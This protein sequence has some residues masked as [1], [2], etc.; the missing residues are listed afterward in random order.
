MKED[1]P[2]NWKSD[3]LTLIK[4]IPGQVVAVIAFI[5]A[6]VG[7]F[8]LLEWDYKT[9]ILTSISILL[10]TISIY[11]YCK[12]SIN[13]QTTFQKG[14]QVLHQPVYP[15]WLRRFALTL[16]I[17]IP[18][19]LGAIGIRWLR[20]KNSPP[21]K[22][23]I[24]IANLEGKDH[25]YGIT[26]IVFENLSEAVSGYSDVEI[27][28]LGKVMHS[29]QEGKTLEES[30][31]AAR[32]EGKK[33]KA[34]IVLWGSYVKTNE[35]VSVTIYLEILR[36][37]LNKILRKDREVLTLPV[38]ALETL[39][40]HAQLT[41]ELKYL[42][43]LII[44]IA[45]YEAGDYDGAIDRLSIAAS[46]QSAVPEQI[47]EPAILYS[48][49]GAAFLFT[50]R[51]SLAVADFTEVI[52]SA[53]KISNS[54]IDLPGLYYTR[55]IAHLVNGDLDLQ[56][57][58]ENDPKYIVAYI[59]SKE[60]GKQSEPSEKIRR[61]YSLAIEDFNK[62]I[63]LNKDNLEVYKTRALAYHL[64]EDYD[65][66][67]ADYT[68]LIESKYRN[69]DAAYYNRGVAYYEKGEPAKAMAD[70][71]QAIQLNPDSKAYNARGT[72]YAEQKQ[73]DLAISEFGKV[74]QL[75]KYSDIGY[76]NRGK[77]YAEKGELDLAI[78]DFNNAIR[79]N[80]NYTDAY[81]E[82]GEVHKAKNNYDLAIMD[83]TKVIETKLSRPEE[84]INFIAALGQRGEIH[85]EK[86]EYDSAIADFNGIIN[87]KPSFDDIVSV[88]PP[89]V[90]FL[91]G[92]AYLERGSYDLAIADFNKII[93]VK[94][95]AANYLNRAI[96]YQKTG[97]SEL[98]LA[99]VN[100][101]I[102]MKNDFA[103]AYLA[104]GNIYTDDGKLDLA[105]SD[106]NEAIRLDR[107]LAEAYVSRANA[108]SQKENE[109]LA[110][111]DCDAA[112]RLNPKLPVAYFNR[113]NSYSK[114]GEFYKA[115]S[116]Y[117]EALKLQPN[118]DKVKSNLAI[119]YYNRGLFHKKEGE[120]DKAAADFRKALELTDDPSLR[121][122]AEKNLQ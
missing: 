67:I 35:K 17:L 97:K 28:S 101:A 69:I 59:G 32:E 119:T 96:A 80:P 58:N 111:S 66:A 24:L 23:I 56:L 98:A 110:I 91:R 94:P 54:N 46:P 21:D 51:G 120:V 49:R 8:R 57:L 45:R 33:Q 74:I 116:D 60:H 55:G 62:A 76:F 79:L 108:Y 106:F 36:N 15:V 75:S 52:N 63:E 41:D 5:T 115:I 77:V 38:A 85:L 89:M 43:F 2:G 84:I 90:Y 61:E 83:F 25:D 68:K 11:I 112:I 12:R 104:R 47:V 16:V 10:W 3:L 48:Y 18:I 102:K 53:Q 92:T 107:N 27:R 64:N 42:T 44:G 114:K 40:I 7:V 95:D 82:R 78:S 121:R 103:G 87:F 118:Y 30:R 31:Q 29:I 6:V 109:E 26:R 70:F 1:S 13:R 19:G 72:I 99:D 34:S 20:L 88:P 86:G 105:I 81:Y 73:Y 117:N 122:D 100:E 93:H 71:D 37:G 22:T 39:T 65:L 50:N 14:V 4:G 113:A 9:A